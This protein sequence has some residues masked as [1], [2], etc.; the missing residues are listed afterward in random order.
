MEQRSGLKRRRENQGLV[1]T[2]HNPEIYKKERKKQDCSKSLFTPVVY[3]FL[4]LP[5]SRPHNVFNL[6]PGNAT[7]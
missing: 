1:G 7:E 5:R 3:S 2:T 6:G 4:T